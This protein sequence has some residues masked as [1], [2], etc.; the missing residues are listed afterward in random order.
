[1]RSIGANYKIGFFSLFII[2]R[3][4]SE[5]PELFLIDHYKY[6]KCADGL[7]IRES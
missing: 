1:M 7:W 2:D 3:K 6:P 5:K 4:K